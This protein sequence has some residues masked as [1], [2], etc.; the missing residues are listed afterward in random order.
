MNDAIEKAAI[1]I[2]SVCGMDLT[3]NQRYD[4]ARAV[5]A[6]LA[7]PQPIAWAVA[8]AN[9]NIIETSFTT[10][11]RTAEED[12]RQGYG[13]VADWVHL[14]PWHVVQLYATDITPTIVAKEKVIQ[15][16]IAW[17][18]NP[19]PDGSKA[20]VQLDDDLQAAVDAIIDQCRRGIDQ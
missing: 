19:H 7:L 18:L 14:G 13:M 4:A 15:T 20:S 2:G 1:A 9:G 17:G 3:W 11:K 5:V 12:A 6:A 8:H 10:N 16:A